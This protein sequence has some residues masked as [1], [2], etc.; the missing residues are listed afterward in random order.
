MPTI[1]HQGVREAGIWVLVLV[2]VS[3]QLRGV[4][5]NF[6]FDFAKHRLSRSN[7]CVLHKSSP[8]VRLANDKLGISPLVLRIDYTSAVRQTYQ[9][10]FQ[11]EIGY[12]FCSS[13]DILSLSGLHISFRWPLFEYQIGANRFLKSLGPSNIP[14]SSSKSTCYCFGCCGV[15]LFQRQDMILHPLPITLLCP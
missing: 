15:D 4:A 7:D 13:L 11:H 8:F 9:A 12:R 6:G 5:V 14:V 3:L 1:S 2:S 10:V